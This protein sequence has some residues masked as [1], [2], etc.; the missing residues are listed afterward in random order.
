MTDSEQPAAHYLSTVPTGN[1]EVDGYRKRLLRQPYDADAWFGLLRTVKYANEP[2]LLYDSY[3]DA[4]KQ[5][6][7]SGHL[8][9]AFAELEISRGNK[10]SAEAVFNNNLFNV[11]SI[12]LWQ[13]YLNYV[14]KSNMDD[15]GLVSGPESRSTVTDCYKLVLEN[16]GCDREAGKIWMD[17]INFISSVQTHAQYE[18]QQKNDQLREAYH[19]AVSIPVLKVEEIWKKYDVFENS[20]DRAT[21]KQQLSRMSSSYMSAR[22]ALREMNKMWDAIKRSQPPHGLPVPAKWSRREVDH[23]DAWKKYLKWELSNPLRMDDTSALHKRIV[24]AYNQACMALRFYPE[25]WIEFADYLLSQELSNEAL[26]KL[27]SASHVLPESMAVQFAYAEMA[28]RLK[29]LSVSKQVY[30]QMVSAT[31]AGIESTSERYTLKLEKLEKLIK[32]L[33]AKKDNDAEEDDDAMQGV[34]DRAGDMSII[35]SDSESDDD[36]STM[37]ENNNGIADDMSEASFYGNTN[38]GMSYGNQDDDEP[39]TRAERER[40]AIE[41]RM[42]KIKARMESRLEEK[43]E[44]YTLTWIMY[45]RY[46]QR[47]E[48]IESVR[49]LLRQVRNE[50]AGYITYHVYVAVALMEYH[51]AKK[52]VIAGKLFELCAKTYSD[53]PDFIAEYMSYLISSGD[54]TNVR[55]LFERF[56][57]TSVGDSGHLWSM[58]SDFE[59][60]YGDISAIFKMDKRF[61]DKFSHENLLTRMAARYSYL[62]VNKVAVSEFGFPFR[63]DGFGSIFDEQRRRGAN[64]EERGLAVDDPAVG[65]A[66]AA[67]AAGEHLDIGVGSMTGR[68]LNKAQLLAP[69]NAGRYVKPQVSALE[70]YNPP[71]EPFSAEEAL[72]YTMTPISAGGIGRPDS[73]AAF[74]PSSLKPHIQLLEQGDVLSYVAASVAAPDTSELMSR[75]LNVDAL[76]TAIM[77]QGSFAPRA[78]SGYRPFAYMPWLTRND[79]QHQN[80]HQQYQKPHYNNSSSNYRRGERHTGGSYPSR[81]RSRGRTGSADGDS[82]R[83]QGARSYS[84]GNYHQHRQAPYARSDSR[85]SYRGGSSMNRSSRSRDR[86]NYHGSDNRNYN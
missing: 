76:L 29:Q 81:S 67:D 2:S 14:L 35:S 31:R 16:V 82:Y 13:C 18:E 55:A 21:A 64:F 33:S 86:S 1:V 78:Q 59:Y 6:P 46:S 42:K 19:S 62:N 32:T 75:P 85:S 71:I 11:P 73:S 26:E 44:I 30:T 56:Q 84:R 48:G 37:P 51:I 52:P 79:H 10:E 77:G 45:L 25:I 69:I 70:E 61:I 49:Q 36:D 53:K 54:D 41:K 43:R 80:Q 72:P 22:T 83:S 23:L 8:L 39:L 27:Q 15:Q 40:K 38:A 63:K 5:Y 3:E 65:S 9:A 47:T 50:P 4:L 34:V 66:V 24:Y 68:G 57:S 60:N 12:E 28:E 20:L 17:Y 74:T 58:I 7:A